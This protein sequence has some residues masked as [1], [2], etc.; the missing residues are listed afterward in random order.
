VTLWHASGIDVPRELLAALAGVKEGPV[1]IFPVGDPFLALAQLCRLT[2]EERRRGTGAPTSARLVIVY[3]EL[4]TDAADLCAA[5]DTYA[6]GVPRWQYGPATNPTL[7]PV[8]EED[9]AR[10][11]ARHAPPP[12]V[13]VTAAAR[14]PEA[15]RRTSRTQVSPPALRLAGEGPV[16]GRALDNP[17]DRADV[18]GSTRLADEPP[19]QAAPPAPRGAPLITDEELRMLLGENESESR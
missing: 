18:Q 4:L 2:R 17:P 5:A 8:V 14:E 15:A 6:P 1:T 11:A 12:Q 7:R 10:W 13:V 9:V 19:S 3:P 16:Q